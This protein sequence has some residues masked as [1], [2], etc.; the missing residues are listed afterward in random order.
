MEKCRVCWL[1]AHLANSQ[2]SLQT[3]IEPKSE[4]DEVIEVASFAQQEGPLVHIMST[5]ETPV[6]S[7]RA[8]EVR[9]MGAALRRPS[10]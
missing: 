9:A 10:D 2:V 5:G 6:T 8:T 3:Q 1:H 7:E 4:Y